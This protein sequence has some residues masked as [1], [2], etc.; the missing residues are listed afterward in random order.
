MQRIVQINIAGR[1]V[2]IEEDGYLLLKDYLSALERQ[3]AAEPGKDEILQDIEFRIAELFLARLAAGAHAI[4]RADVRKVVET[5]GHADVLGKEAGN[6][7]WNPYLP[8]PY[9][10]RRQRASDGRRLYRNPNDKI[11]GG[12]CSGLANYLDIDPVIIRLIW[13]AFALMGVGVLAYFI[14][15]AVIPV[16]RTQEELYGMTSGAPMDFQTM[17]RNMQAELQDL[18]RR[19][20]AMSRELRDFFSSKK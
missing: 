12:V 7:G 3:F 4:D 14:S 20:E 13:A 8:V 1:V 10:T 2:P 18:K 11:L 9:E 19:S 15:W 16:A 17:T 5:L 6:P